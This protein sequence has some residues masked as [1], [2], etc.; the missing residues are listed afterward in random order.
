MFAIWALI[1]GLSYASYSCFIWFYIAFVNFYEKVKAAKREELM[2]KDG[3][4][5]PSRAKVGP[6][7]VIS[8]FKD[9]FLILSTT[10]NSN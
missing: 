10:C 5:S 9:D 4:E 6:I 7:Q 2:K 8:D 1:F 3:C